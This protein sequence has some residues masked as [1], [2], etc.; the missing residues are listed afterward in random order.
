[1]IASNISTEPAK[2]N[3]KNLTAAYTRLPLPQMPIRK[4]IGTSMTSQNR[5]NSRKSSETNAPIMPVCRTSM[6]M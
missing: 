2:V 3:K 4:Y 5:K 6:K 1:M